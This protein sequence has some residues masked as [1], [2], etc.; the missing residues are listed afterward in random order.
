MSTKTCHRCGI[1]K[2]HADFHANKRHADQLDYRCKA[3]ASA[4]RAALRRLNPE[5]FKVLEAKRDKSRALARVLARHAANDGAIQRLPCF[6][7]G[8]AEVEAHHPD[9]SAPLAVSWLCKQHHKQLHMEH[10]ADIAHQRAA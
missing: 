9:Y 7:C 6:M 2:P 8:A 3:C 1:S 5:G 10:D 4:Q